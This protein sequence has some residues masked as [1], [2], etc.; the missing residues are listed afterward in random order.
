MDSGAL[1][2]LLQAGVLVGLLLSVLIALILPLAYW[3][4][5]T[6]PTQ[7]FRSA[8]VSRGMKCALIQVSVVLVL[9]DMLFRATPLSAFLFPPTGI[10]LFLYLASK[11]HQLLLFPLLGAATVTALAGSACWIVT[12]RTDYSIWPAISAMVFC[13]ATFL[14]AERHSTAAQDQAIQSLRP[15]CL[16]RSSFLHSLRIAGQEFQFGY[17]ILAFKSEEPFGWSYAEMEFYPVPRQAAINV[18]G[19]GD[20]F[21][22]CYGKNLT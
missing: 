14:L 15:D 16:I 22:R 10:A 3:L 13:S 9:A 19:A 11:Y 7:R 5:L 17:H 12:R 4:W 8:K 2:L 20:L 18:D 6:E 21:R 1:E